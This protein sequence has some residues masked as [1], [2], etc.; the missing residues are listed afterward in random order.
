MVKVFVVVIRV[1]GSVRGEVPHLGGRRGR[2]LVEGGTMAQQP[3]GR[4]YYGELDQLEACIGHTM[5]ATC[6]PDAGF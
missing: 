6:V 2:C 1:G 5:S 4:Q 3:L